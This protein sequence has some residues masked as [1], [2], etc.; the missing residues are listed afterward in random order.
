MRSVDPSVSPQ[1][2]KEILMTTSKPT[3]VRGLRGE[4]TP[5]AF[6]A[7]SHLTGSARP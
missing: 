4:R 1:R 6:L 7:V 3:E 5:D 2:I